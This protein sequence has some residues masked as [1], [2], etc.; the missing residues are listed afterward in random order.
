MNSRQIT[1][2]SDAAL[3]QRREALLDTAD[4]SDESC[5]E[6][7]LID[8]ELALRRSEAAH[9]PIDFDRHD[10]NAYESERIEMMRRER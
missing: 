1:R 3:L 8:E 6:I 2:A 7:D 5:A 4:T 9:E 10:R